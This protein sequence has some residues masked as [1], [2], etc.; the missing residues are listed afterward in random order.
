[1]RRATR[2]PAP[3]GRVSSAVV[4]RGR[5]GTLTKMGPGIPVP[6]GSEAA[7]PRGLRCRGMLT[8]PGHQTHARADGELAPARREDGTLVRRRSPDR[9]E[10]GLAAG[11]AEAD[12]R[13]L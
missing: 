2:E 6:P 12:R 1:M 4:I 8:P 11:G 3:T 10:R 9:G 7:E 5:V 13:G